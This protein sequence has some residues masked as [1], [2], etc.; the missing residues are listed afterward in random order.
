[1]DR[2]WTCVPTIAEMRSLPARASHWALQ[3]MALA[4]HWVWHGL[5]E[6]RQGC[7]VALAWHGLASHW[8]LLAGGSW[9]F[10][11]CMGL[12]ELRSAGGDT[13]YKRLQARICAHVHTCAYMCCNL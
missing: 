6:M 7:R 11:E 12:A 4:S 8:V 5:A 2:V 9:W 13:A 10:S 3:V 1:M